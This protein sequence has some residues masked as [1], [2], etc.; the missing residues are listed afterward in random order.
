MSQM[1][2]FRADAMQNINASIEADAN[3]CLPRI[4]KASM[5]Q[6]SND[7]HFDDDI[8]KLIEQ[9]LQLLPAGASREASLLE[10]VTLA[11]AGRSVEAAIIY[12]QM[13]SESPDDL[14]LHV[15]AQEQIFWLGEPQ[16]MRD[17]TERA[18][19]AWTETHKDYGPLLSLRAFANEEAGYLKEAELFGRTAIEIDPSDIWGAHAVAHVLVMKGEMQNGIDWLE[20]LSGNW[21][22]ANQMR[23]HLWWHLC[24]F[25]LELGDHKRIILL[26]DSEIRNLNS[27]LVKASPAATID[28]CNYSSLLM[29]LELYD[30]DVSSHWQNLFAIC[31]GRVTN[32]GSAFSNIHD[33]MVLSASGKL[34]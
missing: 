26:L 11:S 10:A 4:V 28:I 17:I 27:P 16:W 32:H 9:S 25:L 1:G 23:H 13:L 3:Y 6:G 29:R 8:A 14:F 12:E 21:E 30:V 34:E 15:L 33:M 19:P 5:L 24:L 7:A 22:H 20:G 18:A 2:R 31:S